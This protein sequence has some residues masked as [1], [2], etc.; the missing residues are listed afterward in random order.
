M[1]AEDLGRF[2]DF[3]GSPLGQR[4]AGHGKVAD[5]AV[6]DRNELDMVSQGRPQ[7]AATADTLFGVVRV[8]AQGEDSQGRLVAAGF[9]GGDPL[10]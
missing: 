2:P 10:G 9:F 1:G 6:G 4:A 8:G 7:D 5:V 3:G